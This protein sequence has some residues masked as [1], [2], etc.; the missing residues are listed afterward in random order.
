MI[1]PSP[2]ERYGRRTYGPGH[3]SRDSFGP[4]ARAPRRRALRRGASSLEP[5]RRSAPPRCRRPRLRPPP[6]A[7]A[8]RAAEQVAAAVLY[9]KREGLR[10]A[11]QGTGHN[12]SPLGD[13]SDTLLIKT[14]QTR[15]A[16]RHAG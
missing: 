8:P 15:R 5:F 2:D 12:A 14:H 6:V 1:T 10:V 4:R 16:Q 9:A 11:A 13:L 3:E 7:A